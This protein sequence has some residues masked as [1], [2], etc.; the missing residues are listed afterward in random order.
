MTLDELDNYVSQ[1]YN[2]DS[3][4]ELPGTII[5]FKEGL[6]VVEYELSFRG[7]EEF[8]YKNKL[9]KGKEKNVEHRVKKT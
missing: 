1:H 4:I 3:S 5:F 7:L 8:S 6:P 2:F 9:W